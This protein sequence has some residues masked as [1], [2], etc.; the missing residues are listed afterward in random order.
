MANAMQIWNNKG[1]TIS[2][3]H[4]SNLNLC[5]IQMMDYYKRYW[6]IKEKLRF[7]SIIMS[8]KMNFKV[9]GPEALTS[10]FTTMV[11]RQEKF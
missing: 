7:L 9:E 5:L 4:K 6:N 8:G 3:Y 1:K 10:I 2:S 11:G